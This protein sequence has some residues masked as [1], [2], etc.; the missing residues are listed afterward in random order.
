MTWVRQYPHF[1]SIC[2]AW[3]AVFCFFPT[4]LMSSTNSDRDNPCFRWTNKHSQFGI[5]SHPSSN[6]ASSNCL[7]HIPKLHKSQRISPSFEPQQVSPC[8]Q[9]KRPY[10]L[11]SVTFRGE[12]EDSKTLLHG[13][14]SE[15]L[16]T[17]FDTSCWESVVKDDRVGPCLVER[18]IDPVHC[19]LMCFPIVFVNWN[20]ALSHVVIPRLV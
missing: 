3:D 10:C 20:S 6:K 1:S 4:I 8:L 13:T 18:Q 15:F 2:S 17:T 11:S 12:R 5:L 9:E 14:S 7:S 19:I 16:T